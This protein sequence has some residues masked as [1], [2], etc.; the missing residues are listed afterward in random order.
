MAT[1]DFAT[2]LRRFAAARTALRVLSTSG[3]YGPPAPPGSPD[4]RAVPPPMGP[5]APPGAS[6]LVAA[7]AMAPPRPPLTINGAPIVFN[8]DM[9]D[10]PAGAARSALPPMPMP[11][12]LGPPPLYPVRHHEGPGI[13]FRVSGGDVYWFRPRPRVI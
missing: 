4:L 12:P 1:E 9:M 13:G 3:E 10:L 5:P 11:N 8:G 7:G 2:F 6:D